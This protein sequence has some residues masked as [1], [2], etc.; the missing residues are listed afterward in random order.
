MER[1]NWHIADELA[2]YG[3]VMA[4]VPRGSAERAPPG[5]SIREVASRSLPGFLGTAFLTSL[6]EARKQ[7]PDVV[8]AGSGLTAP[9]AWMAARSTGGRAV[10]YVHGLDIAVRHLLYRWL[11]VPFLRRM[12]RVIANSR[13]T[14]ALAEAAGV[15]P[16]RI[17]IIPPGVTLPE[18][19]TDERREAARQAFRQRHGLGSGPLLLSVGRLTSRKGILEFVRDSFPE[20]VRRIPDAQLA[21]IGGEP[22]QALYAGTQ[23]IDKIRAQAQSRGVSEQV[24]F[25]GK[26]SDL[27]LRTAYLASDVH[28]FPVRSLPGDPEGF[29]MV[30]VEAAAHGLPTVAFATGGVTDAVADGVSGILVPSGDAAAFTHA[31]LAILQSDPERRSAWRTDARSFASRFSWPEFGRRLWRLCAQPL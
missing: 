24:H 8:F 26:V 27:E 25:L 21:I 7:R 9:F 16:E 19:I 17:D 31:V 6:A 20:V 23:S 29:G 1:L 2:R 22:V 18:S 12:D 5:V 13:A 28:V 11:W 15:H 30:A 3:K 4:V 14:A 10:V